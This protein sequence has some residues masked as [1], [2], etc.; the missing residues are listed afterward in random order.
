[1]VQLEIICIFVTQ[2]HL[3]NRTV[4]LPKLSAYFLLNICKVT[5]RSF[6][7]SKDNKTPQNP[8]FVSPS[9]CQIQISEIR[10][11]TLTLNLREASVNVKLE[12]FAR[13][14]SERNQW[15]T[16]DNQITHI[17]TTKHQVHILSIS[18]DTLIPHV[19]ST[20]CVELS[21]HNLHRLRLGRNSLSTPT[22]RWTPSAKVRKLPPLPK[23]ISNTDAQPNTS[24]KQPTIH[25]Q[26]DRLD[27]LELWMNECESLGM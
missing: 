15:P 9:V 23:T 17:S 3:G 16:T 18:Y 11:I 20:L 5:K 19:A 26:Y 2:T 6:F 27:R 7:F 12:E 13:G 14:N 22:T 25:P 21:P 10:R 24:S 8:H 4:P 1:M